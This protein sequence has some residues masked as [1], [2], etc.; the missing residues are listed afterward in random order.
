MGLGERRDFGFALVARV[1]RARLVASRP[2][3]YLRDVAEGSLKSASQ[4]LRFIVF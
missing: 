4:S 3:M 1:G 2:M